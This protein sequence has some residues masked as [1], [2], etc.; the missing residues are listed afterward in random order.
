MER[1]FIGDKRQIQRVYGEDEVFAKEDVLREPARFQQVRH[2]FSTW[3]M[4]AFTQEEIA[5]CFPSLQNVFYAAGTVQG[6]ARP[7][8]KQG[9]RVFSAWGAN[10]VPV[11]EYAV[12]QIILANKGF[13]QLTRGVACP[14]FPGNY[15]CKVGLLGAGMI[16][17]RVISLLKAYR[18][19][20]LV[21]D[22]FLPPE[23]ALELGVALCPL[24]T[25]F[26]QCQTISN[27]L[28]NNAQTEGMLNYSL[29]SLM[30]PNATFLNTGRGA[31]VVEPDLVRALTEE[32]ARAA[33]LDVTWPEPPAADHPFRAMNNVFLTPHIAG[34][35]GDE[36]KRMAAFMLEE[37]ELV[38]S[39]RPARYEVTE[40]MLATL[41]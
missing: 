30:K 22:P 19:E 24:E 15:G 12:S 3:G 23:K 38:A 2:L 8:L 29:F 36:L 16:G 26:A 6:F 34:S 1:I 11:A 7:F 5:A 31:Q 40:D 28:A 13:F 18:L 17:K 32:P 33:V 27:H 9:V 10:A 20:T 4:P 14:P 35:S 41:S 37:Y 25:I 39:G 21:F